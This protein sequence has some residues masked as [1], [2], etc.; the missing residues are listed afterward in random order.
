MHLYLQAR[1]CFSTT[2]LHPCDLRRHGK[3]TFIVH[4]KLKLENLRTC[5]SDWN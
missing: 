2:G 4:K 3:M 5:S 1:R